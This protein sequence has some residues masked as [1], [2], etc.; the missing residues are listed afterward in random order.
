[1]HACLGLGLGPPGVRSFSSGCM[2]HPSPLITPGMHDSPV[3]VKRRKARD[4]ATLKDRVMQDPAFL[5]VMMGWVG[6]ASERTCVCPRVCVS[7]C[8]CVCVCVRARGCV[9]VCLR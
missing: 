6:C 8:V 2:P 7:V 4:M 3:V 9:R 5:Q 1:M